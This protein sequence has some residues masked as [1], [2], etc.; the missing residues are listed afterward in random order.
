MR[1]LIFDFDGV[2]LDTVK[3]K[4]E[5]FCQLFESYGEDVARRALQLHI[6]TPGLYRQD[7]IRRCYRELLGR[8][9]FQNEVDVQVRRFA[10]L[11]LAYALVA[12]WIAGA[13]RFI[14]SPRP[15]RRYIASAAPVD[16]VRQI[17]AERRM[18]R[19]FIN[20]Y[21]G[22]E[23]KDVIL[24]RIREN[25]GVS[26]GQILFIGDS[27]SDLAA[28]QKSG[29]SFLGISHPERDNLFPPNVATLPNLRG[30]ATYL[31]ERGSGCST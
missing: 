29:V 28:A 20:I 21:G 27:L 7:K 17:V 31:D 8:E 2:L 30:L 9:P 19:F 11:C 13:E 22:P 23:K 10:D 14:T 16:E 25:E 4:G 3:A 15:E 5:A 12:P 24:T 1:V 26:P 18:L 6:S